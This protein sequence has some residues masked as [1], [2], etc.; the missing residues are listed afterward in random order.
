[1]SG[2]TNFSKNL[3]QHQ[4]NQIEIGY[5]ADIAQKIITTKDFYILL[6]EQNIA[7]LKQ[8][9]R[10]IQKKVYEAYSPIMFGIC[11]RYV[12]NEQ[13]AE[14]VMV[15]G[16]FKIFTK[17]N[18]YTGKGN[19]EG[20]MKRIMVNESLMFLRKHN[21]NLS[22]EI[23]ESHIQ[24]TSLPDGNLREKDIIALLD[25]LPVGYR[26][27][28]NLYAIEGFKHQE[29]AD[30]LG[31]SVNTSKSQLIKARKKLQSLLNEDNDEMRIAK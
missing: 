5:E 23:N 26:T 3:L 25:Y 27:V 17:I 8:G 9:D 22:I 12:K 13:D 24:T 29:I 16:F 14:D 28:F 20:W 1:M 11:R 30:K 15:T 10:P 2:K 4:V 31:I 19:I 7:L 6:N 18:Q 21:M